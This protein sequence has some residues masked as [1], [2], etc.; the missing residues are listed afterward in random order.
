MP[1]SN[2]TWYFSHSYH[3]KRAYSAVAAFGVCIFV[4]AA[5]IA[6][7]KLTDATQPSNPYFSYSIGSLKGVIILEEQTNEFKVNITIEKQR[8][9][10]IPT[11]ISRSIQV[12]VL[13]KGGAAL[14]VKTR[15]PPLD[16]PLPEVGSGQSQ[17]SLA[18]IS[19]VF[20]VPRDVRP[21]AVVLK[22]NREY[23]VFPLPER[24]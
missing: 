23:Q 15:M 2:T 9:E 21:E 17:M 1:A 13:G 4:I 10:E 18:N 11:N 6:G 12:W 7:G 5:A 20:D 22:I 24:P 8:A 14:P 19:F 3:G 16:S